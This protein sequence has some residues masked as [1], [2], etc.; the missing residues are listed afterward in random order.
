[1]P[2]RRYIR[3]IPQFWGTAQ[4]V[5]AI[6]KRERRLDESRKRNQEIHEEIRRVHARKEAEHQR[7]EGARI[8]KLRTLRRNR[9][10]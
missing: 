6:N 3:G 5:Q 1:M 9:M 7:A 4:Q 8:A 10:R 2:Y